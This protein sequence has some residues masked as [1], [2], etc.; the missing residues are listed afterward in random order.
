MVHLVHLH[1]N[2]STDRK[3]EVEEEEAV[4]DAL[5][6]RLHDESPT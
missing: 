6:A 3:E 4:L 2:S 1:L 5:D